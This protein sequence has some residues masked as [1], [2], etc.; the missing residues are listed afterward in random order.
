MAQPFLLHYWVSWCI[1]LLLVPNTPLLTGCLGVFSSVTLVE[2]NEGCVLLQVLLGFEGFFSPL[3][4]G[5]IYTVSYKPEET[6]QTALLLMLG[7]RR[8]R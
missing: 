8:C 5:I 2:D 6:V 4:K 7:P 3:I 1:D